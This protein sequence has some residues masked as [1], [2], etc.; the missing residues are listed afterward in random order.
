MY[1]AEKA[2]QMLGEASGLFMIDLNL[3]FRS[4]SWVL[5]TGCASHICNDLQVLTS[6][7]RLNKGEVDLRL[8]NGAKVAALAVG[9]VNLKLSYGSI[10][11]LTDCY[12]VS[13]IIKNIIS[14]SCLNK[15]GFIVSFGNDNC[16][17][18]LDGKLF[19]SGSLI[20]GL[21]ILDM[22]AHVMCVD[23]PLKRKRSD[24]NQAYLWHYRLGH[25]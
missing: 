5:D 12:Y 25:K 8:G 1:L 10:L 23:K 9:S 18:L 16:S 13:S 3:S 6:S 15:Y 7:R 11:E 19:A 17:L 4:T 2:K 14:I 21:F 24:V 22:N 20:N